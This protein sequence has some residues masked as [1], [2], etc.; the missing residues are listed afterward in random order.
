[1]YEIW[2]YIFALLLQFE[3]LYLLFCDGEITIN[4]RLVTELISC[5]WSLFLHLLSK[6]NVYYCFV[7]KRLVFTSVLF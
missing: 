3:N 6:Y 5:M 4:R 1:M 7:S 2:F